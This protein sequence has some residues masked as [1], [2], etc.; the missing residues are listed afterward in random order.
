MREL[1]HLA[2]HASH[3]V[4]S[5]WISDWT[6]Y[7]HTININQYNLHQST[8]IYILQVSASIEFHSVFSG[9]HGGLFCLFGPRTSTQSWR[10]AQFAFLLCCFK[11]LSTPLLLVP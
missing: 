5:S 6:H 1:Q 3:L 2:S 9:L 10:K 4:Q 11:H 8:S 7:I